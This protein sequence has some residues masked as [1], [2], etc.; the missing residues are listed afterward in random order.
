MNFA[1]NCIV[2]YEE[3]IE[4]VP[5]VIADAGSDMV[6]CVDGTIQLDGT[7]SQGIEYSWSV[8]SGDVAS[9]DAGGMT[10]TPT[11]SPE[12]T[13]V[14][15]LTVTDPV[16]GCIDTDQVTVTVDGDLNPTAIAEASLVT[17]YQ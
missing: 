8:V 4:I 10:L 5:A 11:V 3:T 7:G 1:P 15:E 2:T 9:I 16:N 12:V 17:C 13:T 14:Y 6:D